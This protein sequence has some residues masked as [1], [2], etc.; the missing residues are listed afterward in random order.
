MLLSIYELIWWFQPEPATG[1][2]GGGGGG[3]GHAASPTCGD[4]A[5]LQLGMIGLMLV[6]FYFFMIRPQQ[7]RARETEEMLR[8]LRRGD[9]VRTSGGILGEVSEVLETDVVLLIA[10]KVKITVSRAHVASVD[11]PKEA[12]REGWKKDSEKSDKPEKSEKKESEKEK[13]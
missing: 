6:V 12:P 8:S 3:G 7:K 13:A 10:D 2:G 9:K 4:N 5:M 11:R 1:G